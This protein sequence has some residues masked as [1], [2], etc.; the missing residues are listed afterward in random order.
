MKIHNIFHTFLLRKA[1][2]DSLTD[3]IQFSSLSIVVNDEKKYE[4]DDVLDSRYHYEK[5]QYRI[6]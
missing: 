5:L 1:A 6:V 4:I 3:Q 2:I